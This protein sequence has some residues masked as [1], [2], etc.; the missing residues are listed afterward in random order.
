M[1]GAG[2]AAAEG[3]RRPDDRRGRAARC[4][5]AGGSGVRAGADPGRKEGDGRVP[6]DAEGARPGAPEEGGGAATGLPGDNKV[7]LARPPDR[8]SSP[9]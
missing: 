1:G 5:T 9:W 6:R 7:S 3:L 4:W 8:D 2:G